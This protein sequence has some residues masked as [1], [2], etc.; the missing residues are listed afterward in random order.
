M[1]NN[2]HHKVETLTSCDISEATQVLVEAF[3]DDPF[4][5]W[6]IPSSTENQQRRI[7]CIFRAAVTA[8]CYLSRSSQVAYTPEGKI[9]GVAL[10]DPPKKHKPS[11][12]MNILEKISQRLVLKSHY[13]RVHHGFIQLE[14]FFPKEPFWYLSYLGTS[15]QA[16]GGGYGKALLLEGLKRAD[17]GGYSCYL[18]SSKA[19]NIPFYERFGFVLQGEILLDTEVTVYAMV[20]KPTKT[21]DYVV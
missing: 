19:A 12:F 4:V 14:E 11:Y 1:I 21:C 2:K 17:S 15:K 18:E 9:V 3:N 7:T 10:W 6:M 5:K 16:R 8:A 20:R 13:K